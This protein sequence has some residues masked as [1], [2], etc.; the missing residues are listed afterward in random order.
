[1]DVEFYDPEDEQ[2][3][4]VA[5]AHW[6]GTHVTIT[7]QDADV[8]DRLA[9]AFRRAPLPVDD[10]SLRRFGT[11]GVVVLQPG[12]LEWFRAVAEIRAPKETG[13]ASRVV[14][15]NV[16][17]GYDPAANYRP[18]GEQFERLDERTRG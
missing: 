5:S 14:A 15:A 8:R 10:A 2:K 12:D 7:S 17:G 9:G 18:F 4:A 11:H 1:M 16:V 3:L 6:D 13:L